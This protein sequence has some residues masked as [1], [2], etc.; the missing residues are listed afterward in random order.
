MVET[1]HEALLR[2]TATAEELLAYFQGQRTELQAD[3]ATAETE[4]AALAADLVGV[5]KDRMKLTIVFDP[6]AAEANLVHNGVFRDWPEFIAFIQPLPA[7]AVVTVRMTAGDVLLITSAYD[8]NTYGPIHFDFRAFTNEAAGARPVLRSQCWDQVTYNRW[9]NIVT[10]N[11]GSFYTQYVDMEFE[12]AADPALPNTVQTVFFQTK[13]MQIRL[14]NTR[15]KGVAGQFFARV[16]A[17][18]IGYF[19]MSSVE[20]DGVTGVEQYGGAGI[21]LIADKV[22]TLTNGGLLHSPSFTLGADLLKG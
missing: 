20:F 16:T 9:V 18:S 11:G 10:G 19:E 17:D 13:G 7:N 3:I 6:D 22:T 21:A 14:N 12:P 2:Q 15:V 8:A 1:T 5:V 4:Y